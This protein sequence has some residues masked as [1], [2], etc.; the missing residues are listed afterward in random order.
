M[1]V[2]WGENQ[3]TRNALD[4]GETG[5]IPDH[6]YLLLLQY[7]GL[8]FLDPKYTNSSEN[9]CWFLTGWETLSEDGIMI[10][11]C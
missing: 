10:T 1:T 4:P 2:S 11:N 5:L 3:G 9:D 8:L 6:Q 7:T